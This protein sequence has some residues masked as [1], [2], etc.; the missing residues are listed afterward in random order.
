MIGHGECER[1]GITNFHVG[2]TVWN[3]WWN[4]ARTQVAV[5]PTSHPAELLIH[6]LAQ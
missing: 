4:F 6:H 3:V 2:Y 5:P 1:D